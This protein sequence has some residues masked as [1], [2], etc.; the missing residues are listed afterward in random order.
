M[1]TVP[2]QSDKNKVRRASSRSTYLNKRLKIIILW[3][4]FIHQINRL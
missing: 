1:E 4:L 3:V 2:E